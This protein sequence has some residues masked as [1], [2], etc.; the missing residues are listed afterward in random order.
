MDKEGQKVGTKGPFHGKITAKGA[1]YFS[2]GFWK[3]LA[4]VVMQARKEVPKEL[5]KPK[6]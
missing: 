6:K 4:K 5:S 3:K 1:I 2:D